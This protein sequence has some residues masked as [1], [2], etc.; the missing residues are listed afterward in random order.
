MRSLPSGG[1]LQNCTLFRADCSSS[2]L[3]V[4][5]TTL[6]LVK[7]STSFFFRLR[8]LLLWSAALFQPGCILPPFPRPA[9]IRPIV[10]V[11]DHQSGPL[12]SVPLLCYYNHLL[13]KK[14]PFIPHLHQK[15]K[16]ERKRARMQTRPRVRLVRPI[17]GKQLA[18]TSEFCINSSLH[19]FKIA[20]IHLPAKTF[21]SAVNLRCGAS[22]C[23]PGRL[24]NS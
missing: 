10:S 13:S 12:P 14:T 4:Y 7:V 17:F 2:V 8:A 22:F 6:V 15:K 20:L 19:A 11:I 1:G 3:N 21:Q 5:L 16:R 9:S 23:R 24:N 18:A